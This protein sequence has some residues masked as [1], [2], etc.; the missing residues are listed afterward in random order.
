MTKQ[1]TPALNTL[2]GQGTAYRSLE[3]MGSSNILGPDK[4]INR[5]RSLEHLIKR[6]PDL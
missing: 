3:Q 6:L 1:V 5:K 2:V 4:L